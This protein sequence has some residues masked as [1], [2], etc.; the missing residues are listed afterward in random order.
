MPAVKPDPP[1]Q[2]PEDCKNWLKKGKCPKKDSSC[3]FVHD[4]AKCGTFKK[5]KK[6]ERG[7]SPTPTPSKGKGRGRGGKGPR[8]PRSDTSPSNKSARG[9]S[10][11]GKQ[12][13]VCCK[14]WK[15]SGTCKYGENANS[16]MPPTA[17]SLPKGAARRVM[18]VRFLTEQ[19]PLHLPKQ[20]D[21]LLDLL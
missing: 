5:K 7:R 11:S 2:R 20:T 6:E 18:R 19:A 17:G 9:T 16:G 21:P 8:S 12:K 10:P 13:Q 3:P 15:A 4:P 1:K 14:E